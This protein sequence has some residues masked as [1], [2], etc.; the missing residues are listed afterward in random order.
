MGGKDSCLA[1]HVVWLNP[2]ALKIRIHDDQVDQKMMSKSK[3]PLWNFKI[4]SETVFQNQSLV[5]EH[6]LIYNFFPFFFPLKSLYK[7]NIL[8]NQMKNEYFQEN[9]EKRIKIT[10][11][12]ILSEVPNEFREWKSKSQGKWLEF[13]GRKSIKNPRRMTF[14]DDEKTNLRIIWIYKG[15]GIR[16]R[17]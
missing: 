16:K 9:L 11:E 6:F 10:R 3:L 15:N 2:R 13:E 5:G 12:M 7:E 14:F 1:L 17:T 4:Q 8:T